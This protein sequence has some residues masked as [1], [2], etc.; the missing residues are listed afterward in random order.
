MKWFNIKIHEISDHEGCARLAD[1]INLTWGWGLKSQF[2]VYMIG[3]IVA[4]IRREKCAILLIGRRCRSK[5]SGCN[6]LY[7]IVL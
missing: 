7:E 2:F 1:K 5:Y 6:Y 4:V 3:S